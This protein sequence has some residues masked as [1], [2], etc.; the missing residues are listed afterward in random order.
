MFMSLLDYSPKNV[1]VGALSE[2]R[3]R[4]FSDYLTQVNGFDLQQFE[5]IHFLG[6]GGI[7][8]VKILKEN[9]Y[10][11]CKFSVDCSTPVNRS[12]CDGIS[13]Y[14]IY[15]TGKM[16]KVSGENKELIMSEHAKVLNP[17]YSIEEMSEILDLIVEH[18][19]GK[20][21]HTLET[22]DAR[23]KLMLHNSDVFKVNAN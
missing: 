14:C 17:Y 2:F 3:G 18:Q 4:R 5:R 23:A 20:E 12:F 1:A 13:N 15:G 9:G 21:Y 8:K 6:C 19:R 7:E 10:S 11:D 22:F 16:I